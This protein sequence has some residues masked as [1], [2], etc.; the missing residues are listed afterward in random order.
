M[1]YDQTSRNLSIQKSLILDLCVLT[2]AMSRTSK[3]MLLRFPSIYH[4]N[5]IAYEQSLC[6]MQEKGKQYCIFIPSR[7]PDLWTALE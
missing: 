6:L 4:K 7:Q 1:I 3:A 2:K 5:C